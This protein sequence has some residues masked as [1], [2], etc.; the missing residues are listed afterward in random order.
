VE[1]FEYA[2]DLGL[3]VADLERIVLKEVEV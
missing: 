2:A 3:G 1:T